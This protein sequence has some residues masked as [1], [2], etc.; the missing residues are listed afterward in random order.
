M[1]TWYNS[2]IFKSDFTNMVNH[3]VLK[4]ILKISEPNGN[5]GKI[6]NL[7]KENWKLNNIS[8]IGYN[9][10]INVDKNLLFYFKYKD[11]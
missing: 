8:S 4:M 1:N 9:S 11:K 2:F 10:K 6:F 7:S 3:F 5:C